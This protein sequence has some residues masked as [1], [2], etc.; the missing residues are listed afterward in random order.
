MKHFVILI[1]TFLLACILAAA[2]YVG[3]EAYTFLKTAPEAPGREVHVLI[4]QGETFD[5]VAKK[6]EKE[7]II[8]SVRYFHIMARFEK[9]L[10]SIKAGEFKLNTGW[11]P[12]EVLDALVEGKAILHK[13][14]I[15]EGLTWWETGQVVEKAGYGDFEEFKALVHDKELLAKYNIPF[16]N[17]EG[18]LYPETYLLPRAESV[19]TKFVVELLLKSFWENAEELLPEGATNATEVARLVTLASLVEKETAVPAERRRVAGVYAKRLEIG[20]L[21]QCDPTIIYGLGEEY[22]GNIKRSH[23]EDPKNP[24]NT[25]VHPGLPPGPICSPGL[26]SLKA[27][28]DPEQHEF[29]YF[30]ATGEDDGSHYFSRSLREHN[31][32]IQKY[33]R[34]LREKRSQQN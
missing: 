8:T 24:Y 13:L 4:E 3:Y 21:L 18:F 16:E 9:K 11:T 1:F 32:N 30:V 17:A 29:L 20:M 15:P 27:A 28:A 19:D 23:L 10:S 5:H 26:A 6:L 12:K 7:N 14:S 2:A 31:N 33:H 34:K 22:D 25:Y